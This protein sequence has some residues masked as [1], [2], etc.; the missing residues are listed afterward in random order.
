MTTY[1]VAM[2]GS[3][4][5]KG[6][7]SSPWRTINKA[8]ANLK[9]GDE[10][11]VRSG[12]YKEGVVINKDGAAGN[13]ITIRSEVPGGAK[14]V[15]P[16]EKHGV[17]ISANYINFDGFDVSG[18]KNSGIVAN[19]LHHVNITDNIVHDNVSN[20][21]YVGKFDFATIAGN[22]VY[23]NAARGPASGIHLKAAYN[24][25][26]NNSDNGFRII[27]RDNV[28]FGNKREYGATTDG[29][30]ISLDDFRNTQIPSLPAYKFKSLVE[31][32]IVHSNTGRGIQLGWTDYATIRNNISAHNNADGRKGVWLSELANQASHNNTWT[33]NISI[34]DAGNPAISNVSYSGDG[35]NRSVSWSNNTTWNGTK[36]ADSVYANFG[37]SLPSDANNNLGTDPGLSLSEIKAKAAALTSAAALSKAAADT[38]T[39]A[40]A[41]DLVLDVDET[42][43][44]SAGNDKLT[45][46]AGSEKL[47]GLAG[48][49][50]VTGRAGS[51][52]LVGGAGDDQLSGGKGSD[53]LQGGKGNDLLQGGTGKDVLVGGAGADEFVFRFVAEAGRGGQRDVI[54]DFSHRQGDEIDLS[55]IDA[56]AGT[57]GNQS[58]S[59]IGSKGFSGKA[60]ELQYKN[61]IVSGDVN[62][63]KAAD[64]HIEIANHHGLVGGDFIL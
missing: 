49:D 43:T 58:F 39:T 61:G 52:T 5:G 44:G 55:G 46:G 50:T 34:T 29:N 9:P 57:D 38:T 6:T 32:N 11:V 40:A 36:G 22:T 59:F 13:Y 8:T 30:G 54:R 7:A 20:G 23:G 1:Y 35:A 48:D 56:N 27:V 53:L 42:F 41:A 4:S 2:S 64:F 25:T 26:G 31:N 28:S 12:T 47:T 18:S 19:G 62:G 33:G 16:G 10:V 21:I 24:I 37:N 14:I 45:G 3:D 63:D 51:D 15:P 60:A 17:T